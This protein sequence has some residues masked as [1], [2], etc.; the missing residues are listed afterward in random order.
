IDIPPFL[1]LLADI[2]T[3]DPDVYPIDAL[4]KNL[5]NA[6]CFEIHHTQPSPLQCNKAMHG[7]NNY[8]QHCKPQNTFL[9]DSFQN[10][11]AACEL[12]KTVRK[13]GHQSPKPINLTN[14][15]L[16]AGKYPNCHHKDAAQ[17]KF[18]IIDCDLPQ[19]RDPPSPLVPVHL[20]KVV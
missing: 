8:T 4:P 13:K 15:N 16:T 17:C 5:T 14:C 2:N 20:D 3:L 7:V 11:A 10:V 12:P 9:H 19:R 6:Q 18:F 1:L